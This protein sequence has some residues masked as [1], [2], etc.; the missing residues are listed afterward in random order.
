MLTKIYYCTEGTKLNGWRKSDAS[1]VNRSVQIHPWVFDIS[2]QFWVK[3][4][5]TVILKRH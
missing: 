5:S 3:W 4:A 2:L 1:T